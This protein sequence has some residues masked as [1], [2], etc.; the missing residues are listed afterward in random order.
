MGGVWADRL[1]RRAVMLTA[2]A[3]RLVTQGVIAALLISGRAEIWELVVTQA[4]YGAATAFFNVRPDASAVAPNPSL[5]FLTA[6]VL[7]IIIDNNGNV[8]F[9]GITAVTNPI[10]H[11]NGAFRD[12]FATSISETG[13]PPNV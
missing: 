1:S 4:V 10:Q 8:G 3:V 7:R 2:D 13:T 6:N 11:S 5:R 12:P 9:G